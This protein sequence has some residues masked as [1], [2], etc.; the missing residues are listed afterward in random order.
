MKLFVITPLFLIAPAYAFSPGNIPDL[1]PKVSQESSVVSDIDRPRYDPLGLYPE[2]SPERQ[3]EGLLRPLEEVP[4]AYKAVK[5]PL[6]IYEN[7]AEVDAKAKMSMS[8]PFLAR[9]VMLDGSLPGD[10]GF[11]PFNFSSNTESLQWYRTAEVKHARLAMLAAAGWP[12][13]ELLDKK[14]AFF[15]DLKPLL[16]FQDRVPSILNGGLS[17]TPASFWAA[18][19]GVAFA[20]ETFGFLKEKNASEAG[21]T[22]TPGDLGFDPFGLSSLQS[23]EEKKFVLEAELF[24]GRLSMLAITGFAIQEWWTQNAVVNETPIFFKPLNVAIQQFLDAGANSV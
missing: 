21:K 19:L 24:N 14:L 5:D 18:A 2:D 12:L 15:A 16:V 1:K 11:D 4:E 22:Y 17:R 20:I 23:A 8:L 13:S 7:K 10:R 3:I 6:N 9:P